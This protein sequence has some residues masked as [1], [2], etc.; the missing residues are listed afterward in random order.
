MVQDRKRNQT[1][2]SR[3]LPG[4][5]ALRRVVRLDDKH[6]AEYRAQYQDQARPRMDSLLVEDPDTKSFSASKK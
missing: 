6:C 1:T 4:S 3:G 2:N 5:S